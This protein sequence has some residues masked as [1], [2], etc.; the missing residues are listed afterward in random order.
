M[1]RHHTRHNIHLLTLAKVASASQFNAVIFKNKAEAP[2]GTR[3]M[4]LFPGLGYAAA[5]KVQH[6]DKTSVGQDLTIVTGAAA[7]IQVWWTAIRARLPCAQPRRHLRQDI[8]P[9][10]RQ[11]HHARL[12]WKVGSF[13]KLRKNQR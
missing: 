5:Y 10:Q 6:E 11:G 4:S 3:L 9:R 12:C 1:T 8:W 13:A 7:S 2:L